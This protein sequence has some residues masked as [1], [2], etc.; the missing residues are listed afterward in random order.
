[1]PEESVVR[2]LVSYAGN[3]VGSLSG[4]AEALHVPAADLARMLDGT[5]RIP[6]FVFLRTVDLLNEL[7][8]GVATCATGER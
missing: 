6:D 8:A 7:T 5:E 1:M 2:S 4:L 3:I